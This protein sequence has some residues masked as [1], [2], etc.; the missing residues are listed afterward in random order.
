MTGIRITLGNKQVGAKFKRSILRNATAV[1]SAARTTAQDAAD[2]IMEAG[3]AN[4]SSA[5]NFGSRWTDGF[6]ATVGEGGG[7]IRIRVTM[8]VPYWTVFQYGKV[9]YGK[10][11]LWIPLSF[12]SDALGVSAR[13]YPGQLFRV[14]RRAGAPLLMSGKPAEAKYFGKESVTI[15]KKFNLIEIVERISKDIPRNYRS[16]FAKDRGNG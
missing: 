6:Q 5:G 10:P 8:A 9:I 1:R 13:D 4:I 14:D 12:A 7:N 3:R 15:P 16:N 2:A 11:L